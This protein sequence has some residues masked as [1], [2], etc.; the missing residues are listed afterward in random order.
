MTKFLLRGRGAGECCWGIETVLRVARTGAEGVG[1]P[2]PGS[3]AC[4]G[5][6]ELR[7]ESIGLLHRAGDQGDGGEITAES[8]PTAFGQGG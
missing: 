6:Y 2:K 3:A 5:V 1:D 7:Q 4:A 8:E